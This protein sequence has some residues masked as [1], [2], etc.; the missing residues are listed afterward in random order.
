MLG[1]TVRSCVTPGAEWIQNSEFTKHRTRSS[2]TTKQQRNNKTAKNKMTIIKKQRT[3]QKCELFETNG[4][5]TSAYIVSQIM[6]RKQR[7]ITKQR[8]PIGTLRKTSNWNMDNF[9]LGQFAVFLEVKV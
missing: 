2:Q 7:I 9:L 1:V 3:P 4:E 5:L 8:I 6:I